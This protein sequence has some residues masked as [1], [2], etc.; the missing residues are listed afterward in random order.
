MPGTMTRLFTALLLGTGA[1][2]SFKRCDSACSMGSVLRRQ[3]RQ[4][5]ANVKPGR[6]QAATEATG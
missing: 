5:T 6:L 2:A 1:A 4:S 3:R